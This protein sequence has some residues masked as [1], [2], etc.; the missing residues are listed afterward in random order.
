MD[1]ALSEEQQLIVKTTRDFVRAGALSRTSRKS[2]D[3]GELR[4]RAAA[5]AEGEG[6]RGRA[7]TR[8]TCPRRSA[9]P[10]WMP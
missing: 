3:T 1:F 9:A 7:C 4:P 2:S 6:D 10:G 5:R 8:P